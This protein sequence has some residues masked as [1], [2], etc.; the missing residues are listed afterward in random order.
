MLIGDACVQPCVHI[1]T[2]LRYCSCSVT[3]G[4]TVSHLT[5]LSHRAAQGRMAC[6]VAS[7]A[8]PHGRTAGRAGPRRTFLLQTWFA[9]FW[10]AF[11]T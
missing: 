4:C 8:V 5:A 7:G 6:V 9:M 11:Y 2:G 3:A 1:D 10:F